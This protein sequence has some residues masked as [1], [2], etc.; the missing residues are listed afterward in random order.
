MPSYRTNQTMTSASNP[1]LEDQELL[2]GFS[3]EA[4]ESLAEVESQLLHLEEAF[5]AA[6]VDNLFRAI[7]SVKGAAGFMQLHSICE[8]AHGLEDLLSKV[9]S[10]DLNI[11]H[12]GVE[13]LLAS[14]D[15]LR[16]MV[17]EP[18][19]NASTDVSKFLQELSAWEKSQA[20]ACDSRETST[21]VDETLETL[22][23]L[24]QICTQPES[25][26]APT[27]DANRGE[28][29]K[30]S[31]EA[32][33]QASAPAIAA[34]ISNKPP[35]VQTPKAAEA[36]VSPPASSD[37]P[38]SATKSP[39]T[40]A[41]IRVSVAVL[42]E[43]VNLAGEMVLSRNQLL[44]CVTD[45]RSKSLTNVA[46][47]IDQVTTAMQDVVMSARM[48]QV[49]TL[50][51]RFPR[52]VRDLNAK[53]NK[54]CRMVIEGADV[55]LDKTII[56]ALG[57]PLT[58]LI[59]NSLDHGVESPNARVAAGKPQEAT[60]RLSAYHQAGKVHIEIADDGQGVRSEKVLSK[61]IERGLVTQ[62]QAARMS[63]R[64]IV[65]LIFMPGFSTAETVSAVS[66]RGVGMDVVR[67]NIE[68]IGGT[69]DVNS[70]AG[71]GAI[72]HVTLPL[73]LAI[74]PSWIV[75][76]DAFR[77]A[78]PE[79]SIVEF[80]R[81][82]RKEF[83]ER[84]D[85]IHGAKVLRWRDELLPLIRLTD[86]LGG[87]E[88]PESGSC[89]PQGSATNIVV[90][91]SGKHLFGIIVQKV[92]D[93]EQIV[94]KPIGKHLRECGYLEGAAVL[95]DGNVAFILGLHGIAQRAQ[96]SASRRLI[97]MAALPDPV[98]AQT[99]LLFR[100]SES[101]LA[102]VPRMVIQR[103]ERINTLDVQEVT[104]RFILPMGNRQLPVIRL[105]WIDAVERERECTTAYLLIFHLFGQEIGLMVP[106]LVD[107]CE[108][109]TSVDARHSNQEGVAGTVLINDQVVEVLD[110]YE[111]ADRVL[112]LSKKQA[113]A[114]A[115]RGAEEAKAMTILLAE[116][117]PFF[118]NQIKKFLVESGFRVLTGND[119]CEAW[120]LLE[121]HANEVN[122]VLTDIEMPR[123]NGYE[124]A[125][126]IRQVPRFETLPIIAITS[127]HTDECLAKGHL[128]GIDDW[129]I[130]L[131]RDEL[132][133]SIKLQISSKKRVSV[134]Y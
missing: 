87:A 98:E 18:V 96:L 35:V 34:A 112:D 16:D 101:R 17:K 54:K 120:E 128:V 107:I 99:A 23:K 106:D 60:L 53:L 66:G 19:A 97:E 92:C 13:V 81:L 75:Q 56:E 131:D 124:L 44:R 125:K 46:T 133:E 15:K 1:F 57:D 93:P 126:Q 59:R 25:P 48:Q 82:S 83:T 118:R 45:F 72:V 64:E 80:I 24:E 10:R 4:G 85:C 105:P 116:D 58:H 41:T 129:K 50:F 2:S 71:Q 90:V 27:P 12:A 43:L 108:I 68:R 36:V 55:E 134:H 84:V 8:L 73:T 115:G 62:H 127:L 9:R 61:A 74:I 3:I 29:A 67:T 110:L 86:C 76:Q 89:Q 63:E 132:I 38:S 51:N 52:L 40:D 117:T 30:S 47:R 42:E 49:G 104:G 5:D 7:H 70:T 119:G 21:V 31:E 88:E 94:V 114:K 79:S 130:K 123:M 103:I 28:P 122:L 91:E 6:V 95:G 77:F 65:N 111:I 37:H 11:D 121:A 113:S 109:P 78:L 32:P 14:A 102:A 69:V 26:A 39:N 22:E 33:V 20:A 100:T